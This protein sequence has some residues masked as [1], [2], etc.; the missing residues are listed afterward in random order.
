MDH[1]GRG[2]P[3]T[4]RS[5]ADAAHCKPATIGHLLAGRYRRTETE[6]ANRIAETLGCTPATLFTPSASTD[7]DEPSTK[8]DPTKE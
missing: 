8:T 6:T 7:H 2:D 4:V 3:Y 1:P 5:L